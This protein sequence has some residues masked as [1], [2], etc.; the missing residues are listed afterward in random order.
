MKIMT[1]KKFK[2][3]KRK[4]D[5]TIDSIVAENILK[6]K[7]IGELERTNFSLNGENIDL[8]EKIK[9][10]E[11]KLKKTKKSIKKDNSKVTEEQI[12]N[13]IVEETKGKKKS[14]K[15][16]VDEIVEESKEK[17][18]TKTTKKETTPKEAI[19]N[20]KYNISPKEAEKII[21][22][23]GKVKPIKKEKIETTTINSSKKKTTKGRK[24]SAK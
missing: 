20:S 3:F 5:E 9:K 21:L 13:T 10:L 22:E 8:T 24:A 6:E 11:E 15:K 4:Y 18:T 17:K 2:E 19:A 1:N 16:A 23:A 14:V 12:Q 7:R